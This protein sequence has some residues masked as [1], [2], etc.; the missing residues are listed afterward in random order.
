MASTLAPVRRAMSTVSPRWSP[1][2]WV[3][4]ITSAGTA[5]ADAAEEG[6]PVRK[7]STS[8][9]APAP[10]RWKAECPSQR[11]STV[12]CVLLV[13][14]LVRELEAH[15]HTD[16]HAHPRL[17]RQ[18]GP[19]REQPLVDVRLARGLQHL[20]LVRRAEPVRLVE[21]LVEDPLDRRRVGRDHALGLP[22]P[23]RLRERL[24]GGVDLF[25]GIGAAAAHWCPPSYERVT[26]A[27]TSLSHGAG[28]GCK[29]SA[30]DLRP[31]VAGLPRPTDPRV[32]VATDTSD[33]AGVVR[34]TAD[35]AVVQTVDFFTPIVD[36]P[37]DFGRIAATNALSDLYAMGATPV[38]APNLVGWSLEELGTDALREVLRGGAEVAGA[39]GAAVVG[40][41]SIDDP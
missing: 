17:L 22:Q 16:Q 15:R 3:R 37:Y 8:T 2:P 21:R 40:G 31:I 28:C 32:L 23:L 9:S 7:G 24:D 35:L 38:T 25:V 39:A 1:C 4:A 11:T 34:L 5:S 41:H 10:E 29:L 33:D 19:D 12:I 13:H 18:Q 27:L 6:L 26:V 20:L 30:A 36:D 14:Q